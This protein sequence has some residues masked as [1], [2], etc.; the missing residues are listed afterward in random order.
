M[1]SSPYDLMSC[2]WDVKITICTDTRAFFPK[3]I[4]SSFSVICDIKECK[5]DDT[6][7]YKIYDTSKTFL[8]RPFL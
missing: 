4:F 1:A 6:V 8:L 5:I 2:W 7:L 3:N